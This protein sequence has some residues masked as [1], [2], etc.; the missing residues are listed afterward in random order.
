MKYLIMLATILFL[1]GC[2]D[3]VS[4][5]QQRVACME[6]AG[7][8]SY[9]SLALLQ[10]NDGTKFERGNW[11]DLTGPNVASQVKMGGSS[12]SSGTFTH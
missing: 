8:A 9:H 4:R 1:T 5:A 11:K 12:N 6:H 7:V 2:I 3:D 10:C